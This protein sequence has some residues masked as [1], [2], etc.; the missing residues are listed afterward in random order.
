MRLF[1]HLIE[2]RHRAELLHD[3]LIV[4]DIVA[5]VIIRGLIDRG[6]PDRVSTQFTDVFK[7]AGNT[8]KIADTVAV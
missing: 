8:G 5:V 6:K 1:E 7:P 2:V 3:V 4:A